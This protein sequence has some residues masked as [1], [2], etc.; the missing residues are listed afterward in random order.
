M[1]EMREAGDGSMSG[2]VTTSIRLPP[3][4]IEELDEL[5]DQG[6]Y[7][8]RSEAIRAAVRRMHFGET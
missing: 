8:D 6:H 5:V 4:M 7:A 3:K 2:M 1:S